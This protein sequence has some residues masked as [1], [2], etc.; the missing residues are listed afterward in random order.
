MNTGKKINIMLVDDHPLFRDGLRNLL[1]GDEDFR[2][3]AEASMGVTALNH[4]RL[5]DI[6]VV[7]MDVELKTEPDG[8]DLTKQLRALPRPPSVLMVS[9][10]KEPAYV[11]RARRAG[12]QGYISKDEPSE[13]ILYAVDE[14]AE[15]RPYWPPVKM[16]PGPRPTPAEMRVL[17]YIAQGRTSREIAKI[18][19]IKTHTV[20]AHRYNVRWKRNLKTP[21]ELPLFAKECME[22]YGIPEDLPKARE[23]RKDDGPVPLPRHPYSSGRSSSA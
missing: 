23:E 9:M 21:A 13:L 6:D 17:K 5:Q 3:V 20:E 19:G 15:G 18:L 2:I 4:A 16:Q 8:F 14:V 1:A 7:V 22:L 10:H 12:A 11:E